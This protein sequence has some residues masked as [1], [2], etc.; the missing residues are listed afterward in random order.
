MPLSGSSV[1]SF[2]YGVVLEGRARG[3]AGD[4]RRRK[5]YIRRCAVGQNGSEYHGG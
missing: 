2:D 3:C 1:C 5:R 4:R